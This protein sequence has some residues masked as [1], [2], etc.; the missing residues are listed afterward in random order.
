[1]S[2]V[3]SDQPN[4]FSALFDFH[5]RGGHTPR[6]NF[7]TEAFAYLLQTDDRV[8]D[9]WISRLLGRD[10]LGTTA[11]I[12][13]RLMEA[14]LDRDTPMYPDMKISAQLPDGAKVVIYCE[15]KWGASCNDGQLIKYKKHADQ[16]GAKLCFV[17]STVRQRSDAIE[18]LKDPSA[19]LMWEDAYRTLD[20]IPDLEKTT[21]LKEF[22]VFMKTQGLSFGEPLTVENMTAF[23]NAADFKN[24]LRNMAHK[25]KEDFEWPAIPKRFH[26]DVTVHDG[27]G[28]TAVRFATSDWKPWLSI[29]FLYDVSDHKVAFVNRDKGID[30]LLRIEAMPNLTKEL[31][32]G[33]QVLRKKQTALLAAGAPSALLKGDSGNG[34]PYSLL[35]VRDCLGVVLDGI[36]SQTEQLSAIHRK[37]NTWLEILF[38]DGETEQAFKAL[39][40]DSGM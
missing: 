29:G 34:N 40:L 13:T 22:L 5:P 2:L 19:C 27:Y 36:A 11:T 3:V 21:I 17:G 12:N 16:E 9:R 31:N 33:I 4:L 10:V 20:R 35:I 15:H 7:L 24:Q 28:R 6:E 39:G 1:M 8:R 23:L 14:N 38:Q 37:L 18:S 30:L 25:L 32:P 26:S